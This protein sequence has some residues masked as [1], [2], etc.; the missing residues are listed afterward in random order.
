MLDIEW[1]E[2]AERSL[3]KTV[4]QI[5]KN[6][7]KDEVNDFLDQI[8]RNL[9]IIKAYPLSN[10]VSLLK[11]NFYRCIVSKQTSMIYKYMPRRQVIVI[12]SFYDNRSSI[13]L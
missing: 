7:T 11:R 3:E 13:R 12:I 10:P 5:L 8:E 9:E 1:S 4:Q 2:P 6:W